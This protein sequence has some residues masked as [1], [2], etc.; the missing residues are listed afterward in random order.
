MSAQPK[1][2]WVAAF[3]AA[4]AAVLIA[5]GAG[6]VAL[7]AVVVIGAVSFAPG[8]AIVG[9]CGLRRAEASFRL[10]VSVGLS[11]SIVAILSLVLVKLRT[12]HPEWTIE[13]VLL[14]SLGALAIPGW[15]RG[16]S[17]GSDARTRR[18]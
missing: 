11:I 6:P 9:L 13:A 10:I 7:R 4:L 2:W 12:W 14:T 17:S 15:A 5:S 16:T 3:G 1:E 18:G 8:A